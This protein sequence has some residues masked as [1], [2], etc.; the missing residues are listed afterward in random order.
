MYT[1]GCFS[2]APLQHFIGTLESQKLL[3]LMMNSYRRIRQDDFSFGG[4]SIY[5]FLELVQSFLELADG[6][7]QERFLLLEGSFPKKEV[8]LVGKVL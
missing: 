8:E 4:K 5:R 7:C 3:D 2:Q 1:C 6:L